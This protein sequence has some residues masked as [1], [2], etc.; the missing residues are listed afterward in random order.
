MTSRP[1]PSLLCPSLIVS[2]TVFLSIFAGSEAGPDG[3]QDI[4]N[5]LSTRSGSKVCLGDIC[6]DS[7]AFHYYECCGKLFNECCFRLQNW[8]WIVIVVFGILLLL[9][10]IGSL[11]KCIC[12]CD[13]NR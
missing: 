10:F 1:S 9:S 11:I 8:V 6:N 3:A 5:F 13:R 12:C 4:N 7:S 2:L